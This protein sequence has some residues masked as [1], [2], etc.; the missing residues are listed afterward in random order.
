MFVFAMGGKHEG[1]QKVS[2][3]NKRKEQR[4]IMMFRKSLRE[5]SVLME[6]F[7]KFQ[8]TLELESFRFVYLLSHRKSCRVF[9]KG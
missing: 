9:N 7:C 5:I 3:N 8:F 6:M 1:F 4:K 2:S